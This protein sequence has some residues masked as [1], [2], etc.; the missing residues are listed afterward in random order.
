MTPA[1]Q[2]PTP[3]RHTPLSSRTDKDAGALGPACTPAKAGARGRVA[4]SRRSSP[5][6]LELLVVGRSRGRALSACAHAQGTGVRPEVRPQGPRQRG[7][8]RQPVPVTAP[9]GPARRLIGSAH[10]PAASQAGSVR[11]SRARPGVRQ[12]LRCA[13]MRAAPP[14]RLAPA[15]RASRPA[16]AGRASSPAS[17]R[18]VVLAR[19]RLRQRTARAWAPHARLALAPLRRRACRRPASSGPARSLRGPRL[20]CAPARPTT[21]AFPARG[22]LREPSQVPSANLLY[23][24]SPWPAPQ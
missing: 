20:R 18:G 19:P 21:L 22:D 4:G 1:R 12:S 24:G 11:A 3:A 23:V 7:R 6:V 5:F 10:G 8:L 9:A 16:G 17:A 15:G 2:T 14:R 13:S